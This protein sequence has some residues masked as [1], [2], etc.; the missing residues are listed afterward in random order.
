[1]EKTEHGDKIRFD[2]RITRFIFPYGLLI[3]GAGNAIY[4]VS[5]PFKKLHS[6]PNTF[7]GYLCRQ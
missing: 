3:N 4:M 5:E 2:G 6:T 1:M 7:H